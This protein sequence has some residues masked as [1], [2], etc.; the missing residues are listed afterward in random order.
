M[1]AILCTDGGMSLQDVCRESQNKWVPELVYRKKDDPTPIVISF[2]SEEVAKPR[3][4]E[5]L[6][7]L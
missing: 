4:H 1:I 5:L 3:C 7:C 6:G 2:N